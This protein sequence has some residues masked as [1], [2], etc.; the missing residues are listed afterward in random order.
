MKRG[1][2][3]KNWTIG[4]RRKGNERKKKGERGRGKDEDVKVQ[5]ERAQDV[6]TLFSVHAQQ[7]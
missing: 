6:V 5:R 4:G 3:K 2:R 7:N 1:Q